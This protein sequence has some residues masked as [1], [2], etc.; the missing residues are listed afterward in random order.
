MKERQVKGDGWDIQPMMEVESPNRRKGEGGRQRSLPTIDW[1]TCP[2][3]HST[4]Q[5]GLVRSGRHYVWKI[6]ERTTMSKAKMVCPSSGTAICQT[7]GRSA[8][9]PT[10]PHG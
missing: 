4:R 3:C 9:D 6:H 8:G 1:A 5:I 2:T 7:P 10:C